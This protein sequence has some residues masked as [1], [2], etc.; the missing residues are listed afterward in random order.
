MRTTLM[1]IAAASILAANT[2]FAGSLEPTIIE[3]DVTVAEPAAPP[4]PSFEPV[5]VVVGILAA[6]LI[7][8]AV[9]E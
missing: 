4:Q 1:T 5:Y 8:A 3:P 9:S 2:A 6:I 7:G